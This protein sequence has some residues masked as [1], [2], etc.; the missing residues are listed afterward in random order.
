MKREQKT[1]CLRSSTIV[2]EIKKIYIFSIFSYFFLFLTLSISLSSFLRGAVGGTEMKCRQHKEWEYFYFIVTILRLNPNLAFDIFR[3]ISQKVNKYSYVARA[4]MKSCIAN[5]SPWLMIS[6][7][8]AWTEFKYAR[9]M[10][11]LGNWVAFGRGEA[12]CGRLAWQI[13]PNHG[14]TIRKKAKEGP[15]RIIQCL[16]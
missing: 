12:S 8:S 13:P 14:A 6:R 16:Q 11:A 15:A 3:H 7:P 10:T 2:K 1:P 4:W 5:I 9:S